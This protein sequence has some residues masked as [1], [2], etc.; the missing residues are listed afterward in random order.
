MAAPV[1]L[2]LM[3][4]NGQLVGV[5]RATAAEQ[6]K[7]GQSTEGVR[8]KLKAT[9][10]EASLFDKG[11]TSLKGSAVDLART[12]ASG[13]GLAGIAG[14]ITYAIVQSRDFNKEIA[15]VSTALSDTSNLQD[16]SRQLRE[17]AIQY[18]L[19]A[20][21]Q[22]ASLYEIISAGQDAATAMGTLDAANRLAVGGLTTVEVAADGLTSVL[23]AYSGKVR[24]A[25]EVSD[26]LFVAAAQGKTNI[27]QLSSASSPIRLILMDS[28][29][30]RAN[31]SSIS[32]GNRPSAVAPSRT[33]LEIDS[34][35]SEN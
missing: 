20:K 24:D 3:G 19:A 7:Y 14:A 1:T 31:A 29:W 16:Y 33:V 11:L 5:L 10:E 8:K 30:N 6:E 9:T 15:K 34:M 12:L 13:L 21:S 35:M 26:I 17:M 18:G 2:R 23:N 4:E 25:A 27:E 32:A 22:A 28:T